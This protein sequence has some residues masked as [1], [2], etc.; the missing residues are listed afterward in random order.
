MLPQEALAAAET[1]RAKGARATAID[2]GPVGHDASM[3]AAAPLVLAWLD[4]LHAAVSG[5]A[6][7]P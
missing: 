7:A 4:E 6:P 5:P 2:V 1:M 3:L